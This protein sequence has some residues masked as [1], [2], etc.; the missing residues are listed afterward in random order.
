M[1][2]ITMSLFFIVLCGCSLTSN[3][4]SNIKPVYEP[5]FTL[6]LDDKIHLKSNDPNKFSEGNFGIYADNVNAIFNNLKVYAL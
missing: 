2:F 5:T 3:P 4:T 1:N 6:D